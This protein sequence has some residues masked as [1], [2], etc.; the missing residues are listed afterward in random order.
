MPQTGKKSN[1]PAG[2]VFIQP[3]FVA[4]FSLNDTGITSS[5]NNYRELLEGQ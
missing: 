3:I 4:T 5:S 1:R 2:E